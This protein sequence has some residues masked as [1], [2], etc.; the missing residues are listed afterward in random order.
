MDLRTLVDQLNQ[1]ILEGKILDAFEKFYAD[2]VVMQDNDYPARVGKAVNRQYEEAFVG[3]LTEFRGAKVLNTLISDGLAV[4]EWWFDYTH[5][6][7]GVRNY[8]Q[9]SVQRW[10]N[11]QIVEE[12]FY[13]NN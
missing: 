1:M 8:T 5:K 2:D 7:Y 12:K 3:G 13:Y 9:L 4:V 11:G 6:D 10:K